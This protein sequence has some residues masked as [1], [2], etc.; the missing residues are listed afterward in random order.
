M[1]PRGGARPGAGRK[2][3]KPGKRKPPE[4]RRRKLAHTLTLENLAWLDA[5]SAK[6]TLP[7]AVISKSDL[8]NEALET[9]RAG[10]AVAELEGRALTLEESAELSRL[11]ELEALIVGALRN[12][13]DSAGQDVRS[14][15]GAV[16][17]R[18]LRDHRAIL[19]ARK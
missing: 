17:L 4:E 11:R 18:W 1:T 8:I 10:G 9:F 13:W 15:L 19:E 16:A 2:A 6:R 12:R 3:G 14:E 5:E 7:G